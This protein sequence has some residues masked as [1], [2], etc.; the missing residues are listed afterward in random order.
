[1]SITRLRKVLLEKSSASKEILRFYRTR[2]I[3][4]VLTK[5]VCSET[6]EPGGHFKAL[7]TKNS[8]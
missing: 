8:F 1:M 7:F 6:H 3:I 4:T 2:R 5:A